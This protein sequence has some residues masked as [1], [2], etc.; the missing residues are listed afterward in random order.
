MQP[1]STPSCKCFPKGIAKRLIKSRSTSPTRQRKL[2]LRDPRNLNEGDPARARTIL[3]TTQVC[4]SHR[5]TRQPCVGADFSRGLL[6]VA[7]NW[8]VKQSTPKL[9]PPADFTFFVKSMPGLAN[10]QRVC[11]FKPLP[12]DTNP[13]LLPNPFHKLFHRPTKSATYHLPPPLNNPST[14]TTRLSRSP[15]RQ[16]ESDNAPCTAARQ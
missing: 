12:K 4:S 5:R 11:A 14:S 1:S 6:G 15:M 13:I 10:S 16:E 2:I 9:W 8:R 7:G 3:E